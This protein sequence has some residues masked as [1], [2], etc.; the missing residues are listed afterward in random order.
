LETPNIYLPDDVSVITDYDAHQLENILPAD[1][2]K[3]DA[4]ASQQK[5]RR[6]TFDVDS[7]FHVHKI[8]QQQEQRTQWLVILTTTICIIII[9]GTLGFTLYFHCRK[10]R[11]YSYSNTSNPEPSP[12][13]PA[14]SAECTQR[15]TS[16][17]RHSNAGKQDVI[18]I[19]YTMH[20]AK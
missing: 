19:A 12:Q 13:I 2:A 9:L 7:L 11:R 18:F 8:A 20:K 17:P 6:R 4:I 3:V 15:D 16:E 10:L 1:A 14:S 5:E